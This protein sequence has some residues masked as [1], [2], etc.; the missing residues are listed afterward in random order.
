[1]LHHPASF[2]FST[3]SVPV[4]QRPRVIHELRERGILPIEPLPDRDVHLDIAKWFLPGLGILSGT[5]C[6]LRQEGTPRAGNDD[7]FFGINVA[8]SGVVMQRGR[9]ITPGDGDAFL[10][11][12][13][14]GAFAVSRPARS[15]FVGL[16]VPRTAI[17]PLVR[18]LEDY[19]LRQIPGMSDSVKLLAGY[20]RGLLGSQVLAAPETARIVVTHVH[21]LIAL[22]LGAT[23]EAAGVAEDRSIPAA[24]LRAIKTDIL[25]N[26][27]DEGL[28]IGAIAAR[29]RVTPRYVH[30]LFEREGTTYTQF[31]LRQRL[32]YTY[33]MLRDPR[34]TAWTISSI[35]YEGG[36]GD[37]SYFN[38]TFRRYYGR[39]PSDVKHDNRFPDSNFG[40]EN[41]AT[42]R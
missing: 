27:E 28:S 23:G 6:G 5:L 41:D 11:N 16:R 7:L 14:A 39:T 12:L 15:R 35:A 20:L 19:A 2:H 30:R 26:L 21:D 4:R 32:E 10:L 8:G 1:M 40:S 36:F 24:R 13:D 25:A 33:R 38:R 9:E 3:D 18:D 42:R 34:F 31:V 22:C 29:H 37:L 17:A